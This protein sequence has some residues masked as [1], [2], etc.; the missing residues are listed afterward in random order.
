MV[1]RIRIL[2]RSCDL[3][4][5]YSFKNA[6]GDFTTGNIVTINGQLV[7]LGNGITCALYIYTPHISPLL[8]SVMNGYGILYDYRDEYNLL[9]NYQPSPISVESPAELIP[10]GPYPL[11][12]PSDTENS[13]TGSVNIQQPDTSLIPPISL[14]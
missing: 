1:R 12:I 9:D 3:G 5:I 14:P 2:E 11:D 6:A 8:W 13:S 10:E 4:G 7:Q